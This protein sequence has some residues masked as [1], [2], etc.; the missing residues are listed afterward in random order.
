VQCCEHKENKV[1]GIET[2]PVLDTLL[3]PLRS[4]TKLQDRCSDGRSI[5]RQYTFCPS[6]S[7]QTL[8]PNTKVFNAFSV[9]PHIPAVVFLTSIFRIASYSF[10]KAWQEGENTR[11]LLSASLMFISNASLQV[12]WQLNEPTIKPMQLYQHQLL[13]A[14]LRHFTA[15]EFRLDTKKYS[16]LFWNKNMSSCSFSPS[17]P[18]KSYVI[19]LFITLSIVFRIWFFSP[20]KP[21]PLQ[22][23]KERAVSLELL[24]QQPKSCFVRLL[25]TLLYN[26]GNKWT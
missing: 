20:R 18:L 24:M 12:A 14:G 19:Y 10:T 1:A 16:V 26:D 2:S 25:Q 17:C 4:N 9:P 21:R 5:T 23:T 13:F 15:L 6:S 7:V 8:P 3:Y 22:E 11:Q